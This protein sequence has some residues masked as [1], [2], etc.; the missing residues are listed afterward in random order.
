M[1]DRVVVQG[2]VKRKRNSARIPEDAIDPFPCKAFEKDFGAAHQVG[3]ERKLLK[4][5]G[6]AALYSGGL[7]F[8]V[9]LKEF[10]MQCGA[11]INTV[12]VGIATRALETQRTTHI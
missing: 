6:K 9:S 8:E 11:A 10:Q 1:A 7:S 3:H 12:N 4:E 5:P 2:I